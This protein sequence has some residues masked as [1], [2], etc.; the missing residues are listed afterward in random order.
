MPVFTAQIALEYFRRAISATRRDVH[1]MKICGYARVRHGLW[2][3]SSVTASNPLVTCLS[4]AQTVI[5]V[6]P[7]VHVS[8][9]IRDPQTTS[10]ASRRFS[11]T[12]TLVTRSPCVEMLSRPGDCDRSSAKDVG[13]PISSP[14]HSSAP[15]ALVAFDSQSAFPRPRSLPIELYRNIL[16]FMDDL[17][18]VPTWDPGLDLHR[19]LFVSRRWRE[20]AEKYIYTYVRVPMGRILHF[21]ETLS[22]RPDLAYQVRELYFY[23]VGL[24][25]PV[26]GDIECITQGLRSLVRLRDLTIWSHYIDFMR[27]ELYTL[28][29]PK[30]THIL[31]GPFPFKLYRFATDILWS[32]DERDFIQAQE[33]LRILRLSGPRKY[34]GDSWT[35]PASALPRLRCLY[36]LPGVLKDF[37]CKPHLT[38]MHLAFWG[39]PA[40]EEAYGADEVCKAAQDT[41][42]LL[43]VSRNGCAPDIPCLS[44]GSMLQRLIPCNSLRYLGFYDEWNY[45][46]PRDRANILRVVTENFPV[47]S[48]FA[49]S[50]YHSLPELRAGW[51]SSDWGDYLTDSDFDEKGVDRMRDYA[52][53]LLWAHES[54]RVF[55]VAGVN[56]SLPVMAFVKLPD[57][58]EALLVELPEPQ[59]CAADCHEF[60]DPL[61]PFWFVDHDGALPNRFRNF[62]GDATDWIPGDYD[63]FLRHRSAFGAETVP[64]AG[65]EEIREWRAV[66][67]ATFNEDDTPS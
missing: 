46:T 56:R 11:P 14:A 28:Y 50:S 58:D 65:E 52:T 38:H 20:Q 32:E 12:S 67:T 63:H 22:N 13:I 64:H 55:I 2:T 31:R 45:W 51:D 30:D 48:I 24:R 60:I 7:S 26:D 54:L 66:Q 17:A 6:A 62:E 3:E 43:T 34:D 44:P 19:M 59:R 41:L 29:E 36:A 16:C 33:E 53:D 37:E 49:I 8:A 5:L 9:P 27:E 10:G 42:Q 25:P 1:H 15:S 39:H 57:T 40:Q 18:D 23:G 61:S 21:F 47:L 4:Q 35:M